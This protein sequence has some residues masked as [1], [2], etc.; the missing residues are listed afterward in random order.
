M[1][2]SATQCAF[3]TSQLVACARVV[4]PTIESP[5]CQEQLADAAKQVAKAIEQLVADAELACS[6]QQS[7]SALRDAA[8]QVR[9]NI[10]RPQ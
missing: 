4:A 8:N 6:N 7:L 2:H 10:S 9:T 1:I 5:A 3:A